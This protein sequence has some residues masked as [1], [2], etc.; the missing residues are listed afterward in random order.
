M[1]IIN[2]KSEAFLTEY[3]NNNSPTGFETP[4]QKIWLEYIKPY[5]DDYQVDNYGTVYGVINPKHLSK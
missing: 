2:A 4:G 1:S 3:L 5:I